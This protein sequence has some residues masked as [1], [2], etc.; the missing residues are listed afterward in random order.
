[1]LFI[2]W[3]HPYF[4]I[5]FR[6]WYFYFALIL[7][8]ICDTSVLN[9]ILIW[10]FSRNIL[11][12]F[13][14]RTIFFWK[15]LSWWTP[16]KSGFFVDFFLDSFWNYYSHWIIKEILKTILIL[17]R[18][19]RSWWLSSWVYSNLLFCWLRNRIFEF[20]I[21]TFKIVYWIL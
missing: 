12:L 7:L 9:R 16:R 14:F 21:L 1:M 19:L 20:T 11:F 6:L 4:L 2:L 8:W 13:I 17:N 3:K 18:F 10:I 15:L 5:M